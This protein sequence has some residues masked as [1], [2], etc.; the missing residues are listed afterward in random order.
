MYGHRGAN[1]EALWCL[2]V[3][4]SSAVA[5]ES[6]GGL[7]ETIKPREGYIDGWMIN[8]ERERLGL[9]NATKTVTATVTPWINETT[10]GIKSI[11]KIHSNGLSWV[12]QLN[13]KSV[14]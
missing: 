1:N 12:R 14:V 6:P 5:G 10:D 2:I 3:R 13:G 8:N 4:Q 9:A 11:G 7:T